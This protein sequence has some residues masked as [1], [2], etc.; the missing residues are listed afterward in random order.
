MKKGG[1]K[2]KHHQCLLTEKFLGDG[3]V[4]RS[5]RGEESQM[6]AVFVYGTLLC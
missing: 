3:Q 6:R 1:R 4:I 5:E 2:R